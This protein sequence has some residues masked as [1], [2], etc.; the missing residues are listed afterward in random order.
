MSEKQLSII[1]AGDLVPSKS[2]EHLFMSGDARSLVCQEILEL[3]NQSDISTINLECP[4][5]NECLPIQKCGPNLKADPSCIHGLISLQP[6]IIGLSNNHIMDFGEKGLEDTISILNKNNLKYTGVGENL[7]EA[8]SSS[9]V[10]E[11]NGL[12]IGFYA[13]AEH[14]F[15]IATDTK[16]GA[17]PF[18]PLW[19]L[20][21]I[22]KLKMSCD[23]V[24]VLYHGGKEYYQYPS[25]N[26]QKTC[27]RIVDKGADLVVCQHSHCIGAVEEYK[28]SSIVYGQGNFIFDMS[29]PK[30]IY[31]IVLSYSLS[32]DKA[33]SL[34]FIPIKR[35]ENGTIHAI[36]GPEAESILSELD[37]R[38]QEILHSGF[39]EANYYNFTNNLILHYLYALSPFGKWVS[40]IDRR[41]FR[42]MLIKSLYGK[43]KRIALL[44]YIE[45]EAHQEI[46]IT[47]FHRTLG[48]NINQYE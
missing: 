26:L 1:I 6:T 21:H 8:I 48:H 28:N 23:Y 42:G 30:S 15:S 18:D 34:S 29:H 38:S 35:D 19:S 41:L 44:N 5:T 13:C 17:N 47:E 4:L 37:M 25:P 22:D 24:I 20:D 43:E 16:P 10:V 7:K 39:I 36:N 45:C 9:K 27:R 14:E 40:R 31:S 12:K 32:V 11:K 2:N 46:L 3:F 33:P